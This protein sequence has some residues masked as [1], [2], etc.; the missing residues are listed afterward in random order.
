MS[1]S[2]LAESHIFVHGALSTEHLCHECRERFGSTQ[3][4]L[5]TYC[6]KYIRQDMRLF[7]PGSSPTL[8]VPGDL[9]YCMEGHAT[10][11]F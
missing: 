1:T 9:V 2:G 7:S 10:G 4:G 11:L 6:G 3:S 5:C 8:A